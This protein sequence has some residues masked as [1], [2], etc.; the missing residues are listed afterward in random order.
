MRTC[1]TPISPYGGGGMTGPRS[2][3]S[4]YV[5]NANTSLTPGSVN[6]LFF[7][8]MPLDSA[9]THSPALPTSEAMLMLYRPRNFSEKARI[10]AGLEFQ[11]HALY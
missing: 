9:L 4:P 8:G 11:L 3:Y 10:N 2:P 7:G 5:F 6:S 1:S